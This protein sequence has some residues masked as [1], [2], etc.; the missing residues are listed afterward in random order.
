MCYGDRAT[1]Y[2]DE[3]NITRRYSEYQLDNK[4]AAQEP[5]FAKA[6]MTRRLS[7]LSVADTNFARR[8]SVVSVTS[9]MSSDW[10]IAAQ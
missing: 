7:L 4:E 3:I 1:N 2:Q 6:N 5:P 9:V 10:T 8:Q